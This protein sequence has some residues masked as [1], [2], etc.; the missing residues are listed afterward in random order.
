MKL[1]KGERK[2]MA[3]SYSNKGITH[4]HC[5]VVYATKGIIKEKLERLCTLGL[6]KDTGSVFEITNQG[7]KELGIEI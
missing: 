2:L 7:K 4:G 6:L 3:I 5:A 1:T